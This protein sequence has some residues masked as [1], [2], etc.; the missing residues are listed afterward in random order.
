MQQKV[1]VKRSF[2]EPHGNDYKDS[3]K[4]TEA[5]RPCGR[6]HNCSNWLSCC[7]YIS[8]VLSSTDPQHK[9]SYKT[10]DPGLTMVIRHS[11]R[12]T[13]LS[14][15][16]LNGGGQEC[17]WVTKKLVQKWAGGPPE[18][19]QEVPGQKVR[20]SRRSSGSAA[21]RRVC[22]QRLSNCAGQKNVPEEKEMQR[23]NAERHTQTDTNNRPMT[24]RL[25]GGG[26][27]SLRNGL[28]QLY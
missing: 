2:E 13:R 19:R 23:D 26:K 16:N 8:G 24:A 6:I 5:E 28:I 9:A 12:G 15:C 27:L 7:P 4:N 25:G 17:L 14:L 21:T 22:V 3:S 10:G 20:H 11:C 18:S 1:G